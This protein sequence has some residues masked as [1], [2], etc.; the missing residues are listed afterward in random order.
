MRSPTSASL[1]A[2][3]L[4][5]AVTLA[6]LT[7]CGTVAASSASGPHAGPSG[8]PSASGPHPHSGNT[9]PAP[10]TR[11]TAVILTPPSGS[12]PEATAL[13]RQLLSRLI[14]PPAASRLPQSPLPPFLTGPAYEATHVTPSLDRYQ[15]FALVQPMDT[16]AA[17][18][19][20]HVPPGLGSGGTGSE[21]GP[22]SASSM[23]VTYLARQVPAGIAGAQV[24]LAVVPARSGG[25]RLW[26]DA[27]VI[28]YPPRTAAEYIDPARYHVLTITVWIDGRRP[29]TVH[30]VVTLQAFI[31]R[32]AA[33][34][35]RMQAEPIG[36]VAC[37]AIF[38]EYQL[39]FS[40][41]L[42]SRPVVV[43]STNEIGCDG[44][45]ITVSGQ[46]QPPLADDGQVAALADQVVTVTWQ[47]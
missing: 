26:A 7:A 12:R 37:P 30:K 32:L 46:Q 9:R 28:W 42:H 20:A 27:Q 39:A 18:L 45:G 29:H 8:S 33:T 1:A 41:S 47:L 31:A 14:L 13:A 25:S 6:T 36:P 5:A 16:A 2:A 35:D 19:A 23:D 24:V 11:P 34:L 22:G 40:V 3:A 17:F 38:A 4:A 21:G 10:A 15:Q 44:S 43:V